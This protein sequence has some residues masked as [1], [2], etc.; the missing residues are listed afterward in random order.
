[1]EGFGGIAK[2]A[3]DPFF[4]IRGSFAQDQMTLL[5]TGL[6]NGMS[7]GSRG[8]GG[9]ISRMR[10]KGGNLA[11]PTQESIMSLGVVAVVVFRLSR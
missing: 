6:A 4:V 11:A 9:S 1:M 10:R 2:R 7:T 8:D 3:L 5:H